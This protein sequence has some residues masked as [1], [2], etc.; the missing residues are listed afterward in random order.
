MGRSTGMVAT[1]P[2]AA[3]SAEI[4]LGVRAARA[5]G[6]VRRSHRGGELVAS[7]R[8]ELMAVR[9]SLARAADA[10]L[11]EPTTTRL[12]GRRNIASVGLALSTAVRDTPTADRSVAAK[13]LRD[14]A[15][16]LEAVVAGQPLLVP[17][18]LTSFLGALVEAANRSTARGGE[19][20]V[21]AES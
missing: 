2:H 3:R 6:L 15:G 16:D 21:T 4:A 19:T 18:R 5:L 1:N 9:D 8:A 20:L 14:L 7:D 10:V 17:D 11:R 12:R 13:A